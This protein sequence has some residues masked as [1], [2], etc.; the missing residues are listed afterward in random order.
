MCGIAGLAHRDPGYPVDRALLRRMT[1][2]MAHR[3]PNADGIHVGPGVG[4]G[5]RRLS[6]IDLATGDQPMF[7][8]DRSVAVIFNGEI[9]NF[10]ELRSELESRGHC[11]R[12]RSDTE[13]IAHAY[14]A[15]GPGCVDR[16]RGMFAFALWDDRRRR[17]LLARDRVGKK[18]LYYLSDGDRIAF[19]SELKALLQ[20]PSF[21]RQVDPEAVHQY[22]SLGAVQAPTSIFAGVAQ[23]PA[24]HYLVWEDGGARLVEYWDVPREAPMLRTEGQALE[25]FDHAFTEAVRMRLISDVP[26]GAFLSGGVDSTAV[27]EAMSRLSGTPVVTTTVGFA[28]PRFSEL[29]HARVVAQALGTDHHEVLVRPEAAAIL[30]TL[31]WHLDEPL[32]DSSTLPTYYV[33]K[34]ARE[35]VTVA[36]SGDGGDEIFAGY[37]RRY[38]L[39]R[40]EVLLRRLLPRWV[41]HGLLGPGGRI[42]PKAD[43]LPR[44]LRARYVLQ[45]LGTTFERAYFSDLSIFRPDERRALLSPDFRAGLDGHDPF[46][47]FAR[48]FDRVRGLD[49]LSQLLYVDLK[50]WLANDILVKVDRM[51]MACSLEVRAPL[52]DHKVIELAAT[53][54]PDLK[55]HGRTSKYL[56][57]RHLAGRVPASAL[58]R[59]K[60]GFEIPLAAWLRQELRSLAH[61][62]LLSPSAENRGYLD[63]RRVR[64]LW[65]RHQ[66]GV[67]DHSAQLWALLVLELWHRLF[68]DR[69]PTAP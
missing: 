44:P 22:L 35:R 12:T 25:A 46:A 50:T 15:F 48:H 3:G 47:G 2:A 69:S 14:E 17:L 59:P 11:F 64:V 19:A 66:R 33:S 13:V 45:N 62:L 21:K 53:M 65:D 27:V 63:P 41:R 7:N 61:D 55:Y 36:L 23:V 43:W 16:L 37:Q 29:P 31:V 60:Q 67:G 58:Y 1:A 38:G 20:D 39:N 54:S 49:P 8:E 30:P 42:Y 57:K 68:I 26:L 52:L 5:H 28:E 18:P 10:R 40:W 51:S 32:A 24:A 34:A 4:L 9:Y 56:L 6:I